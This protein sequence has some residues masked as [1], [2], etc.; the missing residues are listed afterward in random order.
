M[1]SSIRAQAIYLVL[2]LLLCNV[3]ALRKWPST[4]VPLSGAESKGVVDTLS[5][6]ED[7][8]AKG[9]GDGLMGMDDGLSPT[10]TQLKIGA[11][12]KALDLVGAHA[13]DA[14]LIGLKLVAVLSM[15]RMLIKTVMRW[16]VDFTKD[17]LLFDARDHRYRNFGA[18]F[19]DAA[20]TT[21]LASSALRG[22]LHADNG[23]ESL[24]LDHLMNCLNVDCFT[25]TMQDFSVIVQDQMAATIEVA[26]AHRRV[27]GCGR[28]GAAAWTGSSSSSSRAPAFTSV[29]FAATALL[30]VRQADAQLRLARNHLMRSATRLEDYLEHLSSK[31]VYDNTGGHFDQLSSHIRSVSEPLRNA[32]AI[33]FPKVFGSQR[34]LG[35]LGKVKGI[36][37]A[38]DSSHHRERITA[39]KEWIDALYVKLKVVQD[40]LDELQVIEAKRSSKRLSALPSN[41]LPWSQRAFEL[42]QESAEALRNGN[43]DREVDET[44]MMTMTKTTKKWETSLTNKIAIRKASSRQLQKAIHEMNDAAKVTQHSPN[45]RS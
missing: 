14:G 3:L 30:V 29:Y 4:L 40:H 37:A 33:L 11:V 15:S 43:S 36:V 9:T 32:V 16:Y 23:D 42:C 10:L 19:H 28:P 27:T 41:V 20:S 2:L 17:E 21:I 8:V 13:K 38:I 22:K 39:V 31:V 45:Y 35:K 18:I 25:H 6:L 12:I 1:S 5:N 26:N 44:T 7:A 24:M 34:R